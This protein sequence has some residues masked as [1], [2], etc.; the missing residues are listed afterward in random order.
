MSTQ[1]VKGDLEKLCK[2]EPIILSYYKERN[3][4]QVL[5]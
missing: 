3:T 2:Q 4:V 1:E 5:L